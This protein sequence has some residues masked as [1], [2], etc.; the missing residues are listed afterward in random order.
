MPAPGA[1]TSPSQGASTTQPLTPTKSMSMFICGW[2]S[3]HAAMR[4]S[5]RTSLTTRDR[6]QR[7]RSSVTTCRPVSATPSRSSWCPSLKAK[8]AMGK[9]AA[10]PC[11]S[12]VIT[13]ITSPWEQRVRLTMRPTP[14]T[15]S[16]VPSQPPSPTSS[17][18]AESTAGMPPSTSWAFTRSMD[19]KITPWLAGQEQDTGR[20]MVSSLTI[21]EVRGPS[22]GKEGEESYSTTRSSRRAAR[23]CMAPARRLEVQ[24]I[25]IWPRMRRMRRRLAPRSMVPL[26]PWSSIPMSISVAAKKASSRTSG[27]ALAR[28]PKP[29]TGM[30][31]SVRAITSRRSSM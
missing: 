4:S 14:S 31:H 27:D 19:P 26:I 2:S 30:F 28:P 13:S 5:A 24:R 15:E 17:S 29:S 3:R 23:R 21:A 20:R 18:V 8:T 12:S 9:T 25:S 1:S 10:L 6:M 7:A 11:V 22:G 16:A